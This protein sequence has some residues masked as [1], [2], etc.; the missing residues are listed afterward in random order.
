LGLEASQ[1]QQQQAQVKLAT[2]T[3][4]ANS[5][6]DIDSPKHFTIASK[7]FTIS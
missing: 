7:R 3:T 5:I 1:Q 6:T 2:T 4:T